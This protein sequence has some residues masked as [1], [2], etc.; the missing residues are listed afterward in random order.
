MSVQRNRPGFSRDDSNPAGF[1]K[2]EQTGESC[3]KC[4]SPL[5]A[6][7][8]DDRW[9][10]GC[11]AY[12]ETGCRFSKKLPRTKPLFTADGSIHPVAV[13]NAEVHRNATIKKLLTDA[14]NL[15]NEQPRIQ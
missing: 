1:L 10:Q 4:G 12:H 5:I 11:S 14:L 15:L 8:W 6:I 9:F 2:N 3:P 13:D 7:E